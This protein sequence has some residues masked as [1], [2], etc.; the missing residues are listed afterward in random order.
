MLF[1]E[2]KKHLTTMYR[3]LDAD[4]DGSAGDTRSMAVR[5]NDSLCALAR[6]ARATG[7]TTYCSLALH[8]LEQ[9]STA[10]RTG[11][12]PVDARSLVKD[13][14]KLSADYLAAPMNYARASDLI[15]HMGNLRWERPVCRIQRQALLAGLQVETV[16]RLRSHYVAH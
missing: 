14:V 7:L 1:I 11:Y 4:H 3:T 10:K 5:L 15:E 12:V 9:L 6:S 13:W 16:S 2:L 8:V